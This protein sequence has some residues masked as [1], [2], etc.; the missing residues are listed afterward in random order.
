MSTD[1][2]AGSLLVANHIE[3]LGYRNI[4]IVTDH[5]TYRAD[6]VSIHEVTDALSKKPAINR[7]V[8]IEVD[9]PSADDDMDYSHFET[10]FRP[11]Y[12]ADDD[13]YECGLVYPLMNLLR[14]KKLRIPQDIALIS[15]EEGIGFD[16][17]FSPVTC[18]RKPFS[19]M[20]IKVANMI[21]SEVKNSGKK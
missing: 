15:M 6:A 4:I 20:S 9:N 14:K 19:G 1:N 13:Y 5:K 10:Y 16:L 7:P 3:K 8:I 11:P 17:M 2:S 12:R 18:L 21:W